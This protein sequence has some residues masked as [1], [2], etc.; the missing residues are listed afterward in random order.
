MTLSG[1]KRTY[2]SQALDSGKQYVYSIQV[3]L[4]RDGQANRASRSQR[5]K[6]GEVVQLEA[7][8]RQGGA[9]L[10]LKE[11]RDRDGAIASRQNQ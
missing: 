2:F 6:A 5:L 9:G 4:R 1:R 10:T 3:E 8:V 11:S 7:V